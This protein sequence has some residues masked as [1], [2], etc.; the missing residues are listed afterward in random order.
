MAKYQLFGEELLIWRKKQLSKGGRK[1]DFD[2]LLDLGGG[3]SWVTLQK[4]L[5]DPNKSLLLSESLEALEGI[6]MRHLED[7][8]PLQYLIGRCPWRD[9]D[10]AVNASVMIPRQETELL[11]D[12]ALKRVGNSSEGIWV[13]LGTGSGAL[14]VAL[15]QSLYDWEGH[16]VD[17]SKDALSLAKHN[18][19]HLAPDFQTK[20]HLGS[21]WEPLQPLWG[22][23]SLALANPPYIPTSVI[24][25]LDPVVK[26]HEPRLAL[27]G[28]SDGLMQIRKILAG[29]F[30]ALAP[31]GW[32]IMEHH[33]DQSDDVL[34]LMS[35]FGLVNVSFEKDLQGIK[36]FAIGQRRQDL[37]SN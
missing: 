27:C 19:E 25:E 9:F 33:H 18:L 21:W 14:A 13:D 30:K 29:S 1:V 35:Q 10:L 26:D 11:V 23:F 12:L 22:F 2:W 32:L 8:T 4:L 3:L 17:L 37:N 6:W 16:A 34:K 28:G 7:K 20:L 24:N 31:G 15:A 5:I 36:R